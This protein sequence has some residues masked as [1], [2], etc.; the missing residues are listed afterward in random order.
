M[1][2]TGG[3]FDGRV[4]APPISREGEAE[5]EFDPDDLI[6]AKVD[7]YLLAFA[8]YI[9]AQVKF[10]KLRLTPG[11]RFDY[12]A[13]VNE[14]SADPRIVARYDF[15][16]RWAI[17]GGA[18]V[19]HQEPQIPD[20][21]DEFG[22]PDLSLQRAYQYSLGGEWKPF[23][24]L[25]ADLTFF[26]KD[27]KDMV[28][29]SNR[30][31]ERNGEM[32]PEVLNNGGEGRVYGLETFIEHKFANNFRGWLSYTLS[33]AERT[34]FGSDESRLF[35]FDQTHILAIVASYTLPRN[36]ELGLR[37]RLVTGS[38]FTP[39]IGGVFVDKIDEYAPLYGAP[40][41]DRLPMFQSLDLRVDKTWVYDTWKL[42][43]Y[44]SL[45]NSYNNGNVESVNYNF[46]YTEEG[47]V[48]GL[49]ILPILGVKGEW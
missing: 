14:L 19:V 20:L 10:G 11:L 4:N 31:I 12:F 38:P 32:V 42:G 2:I 24:F 8:T 28:S 48:Y 29:A 43:A 45:I 5:G 22:N 41:S 7:G 40:N 37:W 23:E 47:Y 34:D 33:R 18:A 25:K 26:Y 21:S 36:W 44:L 9:E 46:D 13:Q 6:F 16:D 27:L 15:D 17:K 49:P 35:D 30:V 39:A 3:Y 1:T